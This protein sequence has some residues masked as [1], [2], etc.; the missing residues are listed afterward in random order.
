MDEIIPVNKPVGFSSY[1]IIRLY[2]KNFRF[3]GK[4]GHA[5]T[6]DPFACGLLLLLLG[7]ATKKFDLIQG[8]KK[9]YLAGIRLGA[10][11][12]T[13]D[14]EGNIQIRPVV[15]PLDLSDIKL[16]LQ[17]YKGEIVQQIP[18]Q[19][20]A[21]YR[22]KPLYKL[23]NKIRKKKKVKIYSWDIVTYKFPLLTVRVSCGSGTYIR[24]LVKD[25]GDDLQCGGF[26]YY[27]ERERIGPYT[28]DNAL[29]LEELLHN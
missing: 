7:N 28:K 13:G 27:L 18:M 19:S 3:Q 5:G 23:K 20:A 15:N 6:L 17:K 21:K 10:T 9:V 1:D 2:K 26:L 29:S 11:S 25:I 4:I 12:D 14:P 22:G 8:W 24:Q 16:T